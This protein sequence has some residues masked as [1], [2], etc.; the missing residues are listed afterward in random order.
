MFLHISHTLLNLII[1]DHRTHSFSASGP[2]LK[3]I[4]VPLPCT[5]RIQVP[6]NNYSTMQQNCY[7]K[8]MGRY[9][10]IY[11]MTMFIGRLQVNQASRDR[12]KHLQK[13]FTSV[14]SFKLPCPR[15]P[16][17]PVPKVI[18]IPLSVKQAICI[19]PHETLQ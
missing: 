8:Y 6:P 3:L 17:L 18:K 7:P 2:F 16:L 15:Q 1:P 4:R 9:C 19:S 13:L 10:H 5:I 12:L 14:K 11:H